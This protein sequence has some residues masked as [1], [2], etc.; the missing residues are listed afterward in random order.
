MKKKK[1]Y[2]G[3]ARYGQGGWVKYYTHAYSETQATKQIR[4]KHRE[5]MNLGREAFIQIQE[6]QVLT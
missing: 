3:F 5:A 1:K 6:M 2:S 4:N